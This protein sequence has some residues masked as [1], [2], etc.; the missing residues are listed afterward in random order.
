[1]IARGFHRLCRPLKQLTANRTAGFLGVLSL[2][3]ML[4]AI[5]T[6]AQPVIDQF[7]SS[8]G[9][10]T[11]GNCS[12]LR[13]NF[14]VRVRYTGHFPPDRGNQLRISL[15]LIDRDAG[16][17]GRLTR[18]EG[19]RIDNP[20]AAE[21]QSVS[22]ALDES[23]GPVLQIQFARPVSYQVVQSGS[24]E[25]IAVAISKKG[26]VAACKIAGI[27]EKPGDVNDR[28]PRDPS[29]GTGTSV[30]ATSGRAGTLS[31]ANTKII[32]ASMDEARDAIK[33]NSYAEAI[34]ILKKVLKYPENKSS[35]EAQE[36]LGVARQKAGQ[37]GEARVE[38]EDYLRRY[39]NGEGSERVR[40]RLAGILTAA[41]AAP[42]KLRGGIDLATEDGGLKKSGPKGET[43]WSVSGSVSALYITD[44]STTAVKDI[45]TAPN[46]NADPDAH[47]S[48]QNT[49]LTNYDMFGTADNDQMKAKFKLAFTQ[50]HQLD[51]R[52]DKYGVSTA[53]VDYTLKDY[54]LTA[55]IGRQSRNTGGVIGRFDGAV[56]SWQQSPDLRLNVLAGSPN[57]SR[58][59]AP[60]A[61]GKTLYGASVDFGK[62]F[63]VLETSL[64][65]I[66][67]FDRD[68]IDRRAVG[69]EFRYFDRNK[70][71]L[72]TIDYDIH[73][74]QLNAAIFSGTYTLD[75]K[76]VINTAL[77]YRKV[78]YLSSWNALQGQ[79]YLTLYDMMRFNTA[80]DVRQ[81]AIDRTPTFESAML[82]YSRPLS[83]TYQVGG[84]VTVTNLTGT[85]PS[86]GVRRHAGKRP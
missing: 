46:P 85:L 63:G 76:S 55:R 68:L 13:I 53:Q 56:L 66:E 38:F 27:A 14:H 39:P 48:H 81:L 54:D 78:P 61:A 43:R 31:E 32:D 70:S 23:F 20:G 2:A 4:P 82:S 8:A 86:G 83:D 62:W 35:A 16:I 36:L 21:I 6:Q 79:P 84:D 65:A 60:F 10:T 26:P 37:R 77:D 9:L 75:D 49:I 73:F 44:D 64:F 1:M 71:A 51:A 30:R 18:R 74:Q 19:V 47:R 7:V 57:W 28:K 58:F 5:N 29:A 24:F 72:G 67:Q 40:Q 80:E 45:S 42:E 59:D 25:Q 11:A 34:E 15:Q 50:E 12:L 22:L 3:A 69:A 33:K 17:D 52:I 41:G